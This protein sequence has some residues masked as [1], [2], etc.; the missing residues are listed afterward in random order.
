VRWAS[1]SA[2][3]VLVGNVP[4]IT[5]LWVIVLGAMTIISAIP[6][7]V[8]GSASIRDEDTPLSILCY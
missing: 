5:W 7:I 3:W 4:G 1:F 6:E 8:D 2:F